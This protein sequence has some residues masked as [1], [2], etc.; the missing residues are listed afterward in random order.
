METVVPKTS[1]ADDV[2]SAVLDFP[3]ELGLAEAGS[4]DGYDVYRSPADCPKLPPRVRPFSICAEHRSATK[5]PLQKQSVLTA[6]P[7][8]RTDSLCTPRDSNPEPID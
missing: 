6:F 2:S 4:S 1:Y 7:Q 8:V 5:N 3:L